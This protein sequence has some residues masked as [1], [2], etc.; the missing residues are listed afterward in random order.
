MWPETLLVVVLCAG[1]VGV[2]DL[3]ELIPDPELHP[4]NCEIQEIRLWLERYV[5]RE[6]SLGK[7][8][9]SE[10]SPRLGRRM[11]PLFRNLENRTWTGR[12]LCN[13]EYGFRTLM[14]DCSIR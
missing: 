13:T 10:R 8:Q 1:N 9:L 3:A 14:I 7:K 11:Y 6:V 4:T 5:S 2:K 12:G